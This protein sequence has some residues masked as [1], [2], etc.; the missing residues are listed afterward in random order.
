MDRD[1]EP[2]P[3]LASELR[4]GAGREWAEE[5]AEDERLTE[6]HRRR[7]MRLGDHAR[8][9]VNRGDRVSVEFGGH[10]FGGAVTVAGDDYL[11]VEGPGQTAE[12]KL[13]EARWSVLPGERGAEGRAGG[14]A[15]FQAVLHE[16]S[17]AGH[18]VRL[19]LPG[20]DL[21]IGRLEVVADD[22]VTVEDVD[23]RRLV[24]PSKLILAVLRSSEHH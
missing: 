9:M 18:V 12:I 13:D 16:H 20:N 2:D 14:V 19:A 5:A 8:E 17:A 22:H 10:S 15:T 24:V 23:G 4:V 11:T 3:E 1:R 7:R 21:V 6:L